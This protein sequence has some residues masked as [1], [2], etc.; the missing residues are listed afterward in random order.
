MRVSPI[1]PRDSDFGRVE[2]TD[3]LHDSS[4][5]F[6]GRYRL[7]LVTVF[8]SRLPAFLSQA[9][10]KVAVSKELDG[11]RGERLWVT[12]GYEMMI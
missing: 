11:R 3:S 1:R 12:G 7:S 4:E 6:G 2:S 9:L 10:A 5:E 8:D